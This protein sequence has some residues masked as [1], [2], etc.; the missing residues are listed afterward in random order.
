MTKSVK[1]C[2]TV[3][4]KVMDSLTILHKS[5]IYGFTMSETIRYIL[6]KHLIDSHNLL[7]ILKEEER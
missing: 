5:G 1:I 3:P 2:T 4:P 6:Y 7:S